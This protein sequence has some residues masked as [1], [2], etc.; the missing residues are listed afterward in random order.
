MLGEHIATCNVDSC[1]C[2]QVRRWQGLLPLIRDPDAHADERHSWLGWYLHDDGVVETFCTAC[3][4]VHG[5]AAMGVCK[6]GNL[7]RH[8]ATRRHRQAVSV[9]LGRTFS[10][11]TTTTAPPASLFKGVLAQFQRGV[12]P[13]GGYTLPNGVHVGHEKAQ[14][15]LW[16]LAEALT[17]QKAEQVR[18]AVCMNILRDERKGRL[19]V[20]FRV[21]DAGLGAHRGYLGQA[22]DFVPDAAGLTAATDQV[23]RTF[24]TKFAAP[25]PGAAVAPTF[26]E[27][28]YRHMCQVV[29]AITVDSASNEV[30][31]AR[32]MSFGGALSAVGLPLNAPNCRYI[33]RGCPHKARRVLSR[34]WKADP[35]LDSVV[36]LFCHWRDSMGQLVHHSV[37]LKRL[38]KEC[39]DECAADSAVSTRFGN[40]RSAKHRIETEVTPLSRAVLALSAYVLFATKL[41]VMRRGERQG[42]AA[43]TFLEALEPTLIVL[44]GMMADAGSEALTFIRLLDT[45][46]MPM[47]DTCREVD[48][49]LDRITWLFHERG[50]LTVAGHTA[51]VIDWLSQPHFFMVRGAGKC[52]GG[53]VAEATLGAAFSHMTAWTLLARSVLQAEFPEFDL[54]SAFAAFALPARGQPPSPQADRAVKLDRLAQTFKQPTFKAEYEDHLPYAVAAYG[55]RPPSRHTWMRG[56]RH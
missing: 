11:V 7:M 38:Y 52:I 23:F 30:T 5:K 3:A 31:A 47:A 50:C 45:E 8:A 36:G 42:H 21:A 41:A 20:R 28:L 40:L 34:P 29:E 25:P 39:V 53:G 24:C 9:F 55:K 4:Y 35:V 10:D 13:S 56:G 44:L 19:H 54:V 46:E 16:A 6:L 26:D 22:R 12:A 49:F 43:E 33:L 17:Q 15:V 18:Q 14:K 27:P 32:D 2:R 37:D 1:L 51:C 48:A